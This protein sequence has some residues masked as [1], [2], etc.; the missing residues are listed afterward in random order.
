[1]K[2]VVWIIVISIGFFSFNFDGITDNS[3]GQPRQFATGFTFPEGPVLDRDGNLY[4]VNFKATMIHRVTPDGNV[5]VVF[6]VGAFNNGAIFDSAGNLIIASSGLRAI[7]KL[8]PEDGLTVLAA[9]S[10]GDS[11]LG[12]NDMAWDDRGNLYFTDPKGST[13]EK[14]IGGIHYIGHDGVTRRFAGGLAYPN[15]IAFDLDKS[16]VYISE[17][18]AHRI[19]RYEVNP[20]GTAGE[21]SIFFELPEDSVPDGMKLDVEGNLWIAVHTLGEVWQISPEGEKI[22]AI[23]MPSKLVTNLTFGGN[24]MKTMYVTCPED[25]VTDNGKV[26]TLRVPVAG[27]PVV[28]SN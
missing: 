11:L 26:Y 16:H 25:W 20:D 1:M 7:L 28:P 19:L 9:V 6:D 24:D 23:K 5:S 15:G 4:L 22:Q 18:M 14:R 12:P 8:D 17:T 2:H 27:V 10:D 3:F 21:M 13:A